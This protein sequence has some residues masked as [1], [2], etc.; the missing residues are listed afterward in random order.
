MGLRCIA[1]RNKDIGVG[2][3][4]RFITF[5]TQPISIRTPL[6]CRSTSWICRLC[7]DRNPT[8]G[9]LVELGEAE[10][11]APRESLTHLLSSVLGFP[12]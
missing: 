11:T 5:R 7:Y 2:L 6:T 1:P 12:N 8:H 3:V 4:N 10:T 9:D